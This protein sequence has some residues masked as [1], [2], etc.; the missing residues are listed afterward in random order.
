MPLLLGAALVVLGSFLPWVSTPFGNLAGTRGAGLW[1][2]YAGVAAVAG[3][4]V[5]SRLLAFGH[6]VVCSAVVL[7][8]AGWQLGRLGRLALAT[9]TATV[10]VPGLGL[11]LVVAG[12]ALI[13]VAAFRLHRRG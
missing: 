6:A 1:T 7:T 13:A 3:G 2:L 11:L 8:L 12:G 4:I 10:A 5:R 9:G